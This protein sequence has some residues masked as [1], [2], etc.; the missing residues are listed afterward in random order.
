M[1]VC[2]CER[3]I[4]RVC[5]CVCER[6]SVCVCVIV[7]VHVCVCACVCVCMRVSACMYVRA[8]MCVCVCFLDGKGCR[9]VTSRPLAVVQTAGYLTSY[10]DCPTGF[11]GPLAP[12]YG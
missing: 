4:E 9:V 8:C 3:E 2:V 5:V 7:C 11:R 10:T 6:L 1:C 12:P